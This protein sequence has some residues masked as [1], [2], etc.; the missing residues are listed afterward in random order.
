M[1]ELTVAS[2]KSLSDAFVAGAAALGV[3]ANG[4]QLYKHINATFHKG[5]LPAP[6]RN[7]G[8]EEAKKLASALATAN[9][10]ELVSDGEGGLIKRA[11]RSGAPLPP[12]ARG[13]ARV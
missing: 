4:D 11:S 10:N 5:L 7:L 3:E 13:R 1:T 12:C 6:G 2:V 9:N 8:A